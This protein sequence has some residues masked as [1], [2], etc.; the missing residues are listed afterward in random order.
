MTTFQDRE[1][2][3]EAKFARDEELR[4]RIQAR[5]DRL[6]AQWA[7]SRMGLSD[8]ET[9]SYVGD[10]VRADFEEPG[11]EDVIRKVLGD[12]LNAGIEIEEDEVRA[13]FADKQHEAR[14]MLAG[15]T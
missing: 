13:V 11:D 1:R 5:R 9:E 10:V 12:M 8:G 14:R 6:L 2:S 4:F 3:E 7:A 15:D